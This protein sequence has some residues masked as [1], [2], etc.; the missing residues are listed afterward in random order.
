MIITKLQKLKYSNL[1]A[2]NILLVQHNNNKK[3]ILCDVKENLLEE[4]FCA[5]TQQ[6]LTELDY[7]TYKRLQQ[8]ME[9]AKA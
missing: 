3:Q 4:G 1:L 7:D 8:K 9:H 5:L 2:A 6:S